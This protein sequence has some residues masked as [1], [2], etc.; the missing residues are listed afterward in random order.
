MKFIERENEKNLLKKRSGG[1][2]L[3]SAEGR[4]CQNDDDDD[5][6]AGGHENVWGVKMREDERRNDGHDNLIGGC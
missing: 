1:V 4:R 3:Q 6:I 2:V 5:D